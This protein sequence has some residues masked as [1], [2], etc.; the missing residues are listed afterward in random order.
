MELSQIDLY[1]QKLN[2]F[3]KRVITTVYRI[4]GQFHYMKFLTQTVPFKYNNLNSD[5]LSSK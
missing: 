4:T 3:I 5:T 2:V 1:I